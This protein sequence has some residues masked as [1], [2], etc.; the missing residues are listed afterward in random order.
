M[1]KANKKYQVLEPSEFYNLPLSEFETQSEQIK[2]FHTLTALDLPLVPE[3]TQEEKIEGIAGRSFGGYR[4]K[5]T[6][7]GNCGHV[8]IFPWFGRTKDLP[9]KKK[10]ERSCEEINLANERRSIQLGQ[11]LINTNFKNNDTWFTGCFCNEKLPKNYDE[12][13]KYKKNYIERLR[14]RHIL[15]GGLPKNF[16]WFAAL[17]ADFEENNIRP[18][19]HFTISG[20]LSLDEIESL[21]HG[22][23]RN[24]VRSI[25]ADKN[26]IT[27]MAVYMTKPEGKNRKRRWTCSLNLKKPVIKIADN[28][29]TK[30]QVQ[31]V[32]KDNYD[33]QAYF[34]KL[35]PG[36]E[37]TE[38]ATPTY[39]EKNGGVFLYA[40]ICI[41]DHEKAI[42]RKDVL[43]NELSNTRLLQ[44]KK[45]NK[46][47]KPPKPPS[48]ARLKRQTPT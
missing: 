43:K 35:Y 41:K 19:A 46:K 1:G 27:G 33:R 3:D 32:A 34:E 26:G 17:E 16:K 22:G 10:R 48:S 47:A 15:N 31:A 18:N 4:I 28:K 37:I 5:T 7:T 25:V 44:T 40:R 14:R 45:S 13:N 8:A 21:W 42:Y 2:R 29:T 20:N 9:E 23:G 39:N 6:I 12:L 24:E 38:V 11:D 36:W 30:N